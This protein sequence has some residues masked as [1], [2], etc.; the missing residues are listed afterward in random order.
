MKRLVLK[1]SLLFGEDPLS[2]IKSRAAELG[3]KVDG[4]E[5]IKNNPH[6]AYR[7]VHLSGR[8]DKVTALDS[9]LVRFANVTRKLL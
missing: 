8:A 1:Y 7:M 5:D 3:V 4:I 6:S 2:E 9:E